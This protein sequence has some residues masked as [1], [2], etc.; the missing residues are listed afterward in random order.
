MHMLSECRTKLLL[1]GLASMLWCASPARA[2]VFFLADG[3]TL[4]GTA[5]EQGDEIVITTFDGKEVRLKKTQIQAKRAD[6]PEKNEFYTRLHALKADDAAGLYKLG[7]WAKEKGLSE[8]AKD[9]FQRVLKADPFHEGAGEALGFVKGDGGRMVPKVDPDLEIGK[10][11]TATE[12]P[13]PNEAQR[14]AKQLKGLGEGSWEKNSEVQA[15]V[16]QAQ[17]K[18]ELLAKILKAPGWPN[19]ANIQDVQIRQ[20]AAVILGLAGD[21]RAMQPLME[22]CIEDPDDK[23]RLAAAKGLAALEEP[24]TLRKM[25]DFSIDVKSPFAA[26]R[27]MCQA[28]RRYGDVEA[29][30]LLLKEASFELA[31]GNAVDPKNPLRGNTKGIG[32]DNPLGLPNAPPPANTRDE[33]I[34]YPALSA[35]R[36]VSGQTTL[37]QDKD[38]KTW[39]VWWKNAGPAFKFKD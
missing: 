3:S 34:L 36:E 19:S 12:K 27:L 9:T 31:S 26:R 5:I 37:D 22:A 32:G 25:V 10:S 6:K 17:D 21:R 13:D 39:K 2:D 11:S 20:R 24:I 7:L 28:I 14:L 1:I 23:V 35:L 4:E 33:T 18:P 16:K 30:E 8:Q 29:I 38:M 15:L